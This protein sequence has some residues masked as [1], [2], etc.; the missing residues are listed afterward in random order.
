MPSRI[1]ATRGLARIGVVTPVT[2]TNL[3]P[4]MQMLAPP[5]VS[6]HFARSGG[7]DVDAIPD[8][9]QMRRYSATPMPEAIESLRL[10]RSDIILYGCTSATLAQGPE[11]DRRFRQEIETAAGVAAVT[12]AGALV[13][14]LSDLGARRV[15]FASPYV[16]GLNDLAIAF[17]E[18]AGVRCVGRFD[19]P[20][21]LGNEAVAAV[22]PKEIVA[23]ALGA[24]APEAEALVLSCTDFRAAEAIPEIERRTGKPVV[25]SNQALLHVGLKRLG[26]SARGSPMQDHL[27]ARR[28]AAQPG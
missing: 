18:A 24:D 28:A 12:A 27:L 2:N 16:A 8:A 11:F 15:G 25:T 5:G 4:D 22:L 17:L 23:F 10:C 7:Y 3:E 26:L 14:S 13:E 1:A 6:M 20:A 19:A 9:E 21:P